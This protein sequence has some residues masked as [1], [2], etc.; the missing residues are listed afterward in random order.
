VEGDERMP[1]VGQLVA[2]R[3]RIERLAAHG[4]MGTV[5]RARDELSNACVALKV[6]AREGTDAARFAQEACVLAELRHPAIVR[7]LAHGQMTPALNFLAMEWLEGEDLS[8]RLARAGLGV[9]G[10]LAILRRISEG[11]AVAHARGLVHRDIKPGNILLEGDLPTQATLIDFGIARRRPS[12]RTTL[13]APLT[14]AGVVLGTV[15]YMSPEQATGD[16]SLDARSDVFALGC[17]LFECLTGEPAFS[18]IQVMAVL[19]KVLRE[20]APRMRDLRPELDPAL[21]DLVARMLSKDRESRPADAAAVVAELAKLGN[22][23][24]GAPEAVARRAA[25]LSGGEQRPVSVMLALVPGEATQV[26]A[27]VERHG[28]ELAR[29]AN[30][31]LLVTLAGRGSTGEQI[32]TASA[33]A[34]ALRDAFPAAR[35]GLSTG[36]APTSG[37]PPGPLIDQAASLLSDSRSP[38][39]RVDEVTAGLLGAGFV[40]RPDGSAIELVGRR[41]EIDVPR[42]LLGKVTPCVGRDKELDWLDGTLRECVLESVARAVVVTGQVGQGK[43]RLVHELL[44]RIGRRGDDVRVLS[45]RGDPVAPGSA[46]ML[47]R[48]LVRHAARAR[49]GV[50]EAEQRA[51]L[52]SHVLSV[53]E[54]TEAGWIVDFL[55]ELLGLAPL[56]GLPSDRFRVAQNDPRV[57]GEWLR[58]AFATWLGSLCA[59]R[60]L[61]V[62]VDDLQWGDE[63]SVSFLV[64]AL[65]TLGSRPLMVLA[66]GRPELADAFPA[67]WGSVEKVEIALSRLAPRAAERLARIALGDRAE[68]ISV[69]RIVERADGNPYYLEELI[70][71]VADG[72]ADTLPDTVLALAHSRIERLEPDA[73]RVVRAASVFG[74]VFWQGGVVALLGALR[75]NRDVDRWLRLLVEAEIF[76]PSPGSRFDGEVEL[77]FRSGLLRDAAY[78]TLTGPDRAK[79]HRLAGEWLEGAGEKDALSLGEHFDRGGDRARALSWIARAAQT[80]LKGGGFEAAILLC[81]RASALGPEGEARG[82]VLQTEGLA[83]AMRGNLPLGAQ[84]L[85]AAMSC[86]EPGSPRWFACVASLLLTGTF[87]GDPQITGPL[88]Q[89]VLD[90][91][92]APVA[93]GPYG[94]ST[95]AASVGL[96][97]IGHLDVACGL[98]RRAEG[99]VTDPASADPVFMIA[100]G[101]TRAALGIARGELGAA[102]RNLAAAR[103]AAERT[104]D[105]S[106]RLL[107]ALH[108]SAA[109]AEAG[110]EE[111]TKRAAEDLSRLAGQLGASS[112]ADWGA[113]SLAQVRLS[114]GRGC[115]LV[116]TLQGLAARLD[117]MFVAFARGM[118]SQALLAADDLAGAETAAT[119]AVEGAPMFPGVRA[120]ALG[121]LALVALRRGQ[122]GEALSLAQRGLDASARVG[123]PR[124]VSILLLARAEA[125]T[126][127]GRVADGASALG[128]ARDRL[129]RI[130][131][132]F[133]DPAL[134]ASYLTLIGPNARTLALA[135]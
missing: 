35:I 86:F 117:P 130:A 124:D 58:R 100:L 123:S 70:R 26:A 125:L 13:A 21:D 84:R 83:L 48:Q 114:C 61:L 49:E 105:A 46:L 23:D 6:V 68:S 132:S 74:H 57:M 69:A 40:L 71:R 109:F 45:A 56:D 72:A 88:L 10:S 67:V 9:K 133:D 128:E 98:L 102:V 85:E 65:R 87:L 39:V 2:N 120:A 118:L 63:P 27:L 73:R 82:R 50:P 30:G 34:L 104:G 17:V 129:L 93:T 44:L 19:A 4:G 52:A 90:P 99:L 33:C 22:V 96:A 92:V 29:L 89:I 111:R 37:G 107:V 122:A 94:V 28:G 91:S 106:G 77:A 62:V 75:G 38:G 55:G 60:P 12:H 97:M 24:G 79:G 20:Q 25:G 16:P 112:F 53:C 8:R 3:Y 127:S 41:V 14:G 51:E 5:F 7:Y 36:W 108:E 64:E 31:A 43:S 119:A 121:T 59:E 32:V 76:E 54:P 101:L 81:G 134:R 66:L 116:S 42:M 126:A 80:A 47:A 135:G 110:D 113:L 15:G 18:G 78:A 131:G 95:Y 11:L 1:E 103:I 115:D